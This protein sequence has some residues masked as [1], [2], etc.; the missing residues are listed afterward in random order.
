MLSL[1]KEL[2]HEFIY[3]DKKLDAD[4]SFDNVLRWYQLMED[5]DFN[6]LEKVVTAFEMF[7]GYKSSDPDLVINAVKA[8]SEYIHQ[9]PY[10][11]ELADDGDISNEAPTKYY[12]YTQ[13][14]EAIYASF[15]E[16]YGID[17][18]EQQGKLH[19]DKFKALLSGLNPKTYFK[20]IIEIRTRSRDGLEDK[21]LNAL[22][23]AQSYYELDENKSVSDLDDQMSDGFDFLEQQAT[24]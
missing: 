13:D 9:V 3:K 7:F 11:Y 18:V 4:L 15:L 2:E 8:V 24:K 23:D 19:W 14:A 5:T 20:R 10:S 12:S 17:L 16:Q 22:A 6:N 21:E 1:T